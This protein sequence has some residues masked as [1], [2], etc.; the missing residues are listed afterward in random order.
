MTHLRSVDDSGLGSPIEEQIRAI[1]ARA[2]AEGAVS[3]VATWTPAGNERWGYQVAPDCDGTLAGLTM[4][5]A[6][7]VNYSVLPPEVHTDA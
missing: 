4:R 1:A 7:H 2:I 5:L 6:R 3:F